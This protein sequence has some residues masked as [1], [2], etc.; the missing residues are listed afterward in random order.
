[1]LPLGGGHVTNDIATVLRTPLDSAER[2]KRKYGCASRSLVEDG[3]TME[4]P[5]VGGRGPRG[6]PRMKL[7]E[8]IEPRIEEIFEHIKKELLRCGYS[9]A[10]AAGVVLTGGA[11]AMEGIAEVAETVLGLPARRGMPHKVGGLVDVVKSPAYAAGVG[12]V[13]YGAQAG[14]QAAMRTQIQKPD[15]GAFRRMFSRLAEIF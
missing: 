10:L 7:V 8:I 6:L 1:V 15:R 12:L 4:V 14:K 5:S 13:L 11:T 9:D 2:I 3:E